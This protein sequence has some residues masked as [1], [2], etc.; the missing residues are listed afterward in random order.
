MRREKHQSTTYSALP[1]RRLTF[2]PFRAGSAPIPPMFV[3]LNSRWFQAYCRALFEHDPAAAACT[4]G[5]PSGHSQ[6]G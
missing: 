2:T 6:Q 1:V 4:F 5:T 3:N